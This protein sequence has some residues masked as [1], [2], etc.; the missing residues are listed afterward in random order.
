[1]LVRPAVVATTIV[2]SASRSTCARCESRSKSRLDARDRLPQPQAGLDRLFAL[3][4]RVELAE[5]L[6]G[7]RRTGSPVRPGRVEARPQQR[8]DLLAVQQLG[9][10][11]LRLELGAQ[12]VDPAEVLAHRTPMR[13][14][15]ALE[16]SRRQLPPPPVRERGPR[17]VLARKERHHQVV[18]DLHRGLAVGV[19]PQRLL[20]RRVQP[21]ARQRQRVARTALAARRRPRARL[22]LPPALADEL[23]EVHR[24]ALDDDLDPLVVV[25]L[26]D[27]PLERA[28]RLLAL[29]AGHQQRVH[30]RD[31]EDPHERA[32]ARDHQAGAVDRLHPQ[33]LTRLPKLLA[34]A[35]RTPIIGRTPAGDPVRSSGGPLTAAPQQLGVEHRERARPR[36][37]ALVLLSDHA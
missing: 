28:G 12:R 32:L 18:V 5:Q 25:Q 8:D 24:P 3:D 4:R 20:E 26:G 7:R 17:D 22:D 23:V 33:Q 30:R 13:G 19:Q 10:H 35:L 1:M 6:A 37:R 15:R 31:P 34:R 27:Q 9:R 16:R 2:C 11:P 14:Q 36:R 21:P 29:L